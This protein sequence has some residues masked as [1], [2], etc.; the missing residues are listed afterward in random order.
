MVDQAPPK[1]K[2][3][4][5]GKGK[6]LGMPVWLVIVLGVV[7]LYV[8]YRLF[9]SGSG[10]TAGTTSVAQENTPSTNDQPA[11]TGAV[12]TAGSPGDT[13][14]STSDLLTAL[15]GQQSNLLDALATQESDVVGLA[16]SQLTAAQQQGLSPST[17]TQT[18]PLLTSQPG[19]SFAPIISY[20]SPT[21]VAPTQTAKPAV[22][23]SPTH[24]YTF[25][26][27][28]PLKQGQT[29]HYT[30]GRGYYAAAG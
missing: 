6:I 9:V 26:N 10:G 7:L 20:A 17:T 15:G 16:Q 8:V 19:G 14:Q 11:S 30:K 25:K 1:G 27:Q 5:K 18:Q 24:Y 4:G 12:T 28:V 3:K 2:G 22:V 23:S 21:A 13:G 29:L